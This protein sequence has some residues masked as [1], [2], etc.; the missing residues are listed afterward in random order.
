MARYWYEQA[1]NNGNIFAP[2][3]LGKM[4]ELGQGV[5]LDFSKARSFYEKGAVAGVDP[6]MVE[7]ARCYASGAG[8]K[9]DPKLAVYWYTKAAELGNG[10]AMQA[11]GLAYARGTLGLSQDFNEA[12]RWFIRD[13]STYRPFSFPLSIWE[14]EERGD[15]GGMR[16]YA[17]AKAH[18]ERWAKQGNNMAIANLGFLYWHGLGVKKDVPKAMELFEQA[19]NGGNAYAMYNLGT[20]YE[21]GDDGLPPNGNKALEFYQ[22]AYAGGNSQ[23]AV[24]LQRLGQLKTAR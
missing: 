15:E 1:A 2:Y 19:A 7:L 23:A 21:K 4:Y 18:Y 17:D 10:E 6:A 16:D 22:R 20:V 5:T 12:E 8:G 9:E 11:L 13:S 3:N 24:A 14:L